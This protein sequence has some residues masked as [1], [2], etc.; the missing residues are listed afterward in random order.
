LTFVFVD[1]GAW[2]ALGSERD[3]HH[4]AARSHLASLLEHRTPLLTTNYVVA[5]TAT[6]LR[7]GE[8]LQSAMQFRKTLDRTAARGQLRLI[9]IDPR[10]EAE[11]WE[12]LR[13][14]ADVRLSLT[15]ATSAAAARHRRVDEVFGF[16]QDFVALGFRVGPATP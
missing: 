5:E 1:T 15:D 2:I 6:R 16:D 8:G 4:R 14:Y 3:G 7:Y 12:I 10:L 11:G 13:R 9:W